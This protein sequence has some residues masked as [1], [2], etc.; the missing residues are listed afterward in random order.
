MK[1]VYWHFREN[2]YFYLIGFMVLVFI[3]LPVQRYMDSHYTE[4]IEC[5]VISAETTSRTTGSGGKI[6]S[7]ITSTVET[8][9]CGRL[10]Q[11]SPIVDGLSMKEV[12]D[13][14]VPGKKYRFVVNRYPFLSDD[15]NIQDIKDVDG[16][17][18]DF[19]P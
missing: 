4:D 12:T 8:E 11:H 18:V 2:W 14:L 3:S 5:T 17:P 13:Q 15:H 6:S 7:S 19:A 16:S 10:W 1:K 9:E